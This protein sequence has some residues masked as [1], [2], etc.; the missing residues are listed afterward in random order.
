[1]IKKISIG[2][3]ISYFFIFLVNNLS[4]AWDRYIVQFLIL[5][6]INIFSFIFLLKNYT[7]IDVINSIKKNKVILF[8][9]GFITVSALSVIVADN[10]VESVIVLSQ[11]LSFF[12]SLLFIYILSKKSKI[13]FISLVINLSL[14]ATILECTYIL[15]LFFDNIIIDGESFS[16]SNI[17]KGFAANINIAAFSL[18]AKSPAVF[19]Y[20]FKSKKLL[21]KI[22]C[23]VLIFMIASCLSILLSRGAFIAF[24]TIFLLLFVY[25]LINKKENYTLS[26]S[27]LFSSVLIS[28]LIFSNLLVNKQDSLLNDRI[29][30]IQF[31]G[32]DQSINERLRF[33]KGAFESIKEN[34][35]LGIGIGNWKIKSMKYDAKYSKGYRVPFHAHNDILQVAAE[36]GILASIFF[37]LFLIN[38]FYVFIKYK[39]YNNIDLKYFSILL[40]LLVYIIDTL[41]NFPIARPISHI[42]LIFVSITL[43]FLADKYEKNNI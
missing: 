26:Y 23:G 19:Y 13:N 21:F 10:Q 3:L 43:I 35:L 1:M 41:I 5:S 38:P 15:Y 32:G 12:F 28:Y 39:I 6:V 2:I 14:I 16:R 11:Y 36:S 40:M 7:L 9:T 42:F 33:Y 37:I 29:T 25:T 18:V 20:L 30:S 31:D 34:P 17:Y 22:L 24:A 8:Y 27:I 4:L